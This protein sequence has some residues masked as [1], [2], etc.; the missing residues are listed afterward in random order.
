VKLAIKEYLKIRTEKIDSLHCTC[1]EK[2]LWTK[3]RNTLAHDFSVTVLLSKTFF[4]EHNKRKLY[5][6]GLTWTVSNWKNMNFKR[7][8]S[9][10]IKT[11]T[12]LNITKTAKM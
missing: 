2:T 11:A 1:D 8:Y 9:A 12:V 4:E 10:I 6:F 7:E 3:K 5:F